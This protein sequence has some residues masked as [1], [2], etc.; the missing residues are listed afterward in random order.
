MSKV[1]LIFGKICSGKTTYAKRI[2]KEKKQFIYPVMKLLLRYLDK[3]SVKSMTKSW[4]A[5]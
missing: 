4:N 1:I 3:I 5:R 2:M